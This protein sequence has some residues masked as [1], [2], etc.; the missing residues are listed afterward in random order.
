MALDANIRDVTSGAAV[1]VTTANELTVTGDTVTFYEN[2]DGVATNVRL[3]ESPEVDDDYRLRVALETYLDQET[4]NYTA[5]NT[6]KHKYSNTT[7][8]N[9]PTINGY[10]TNSGSIT[11]LNTATHWQSYAYFPIHGVASTYAEF[12]ASFSSTCPTNTTL[13]FG[14]FVLANPTTPATPYAP[15]DGVYFRY[16]NTGM[17]GVINFNGTETTVGPFVNTFGGSQWTPVAS[18]KYAFNVTI[19]ERN[20]QFWID[21]R[22]YGS[23]VPPIT[24]GQPFVSA[25]LPKAIRH[26]IGSVAASGGFSFLVSDATV[27]MGGPNITDTL[28][29]ISNRTLGSYQGLSGGTMGGTSTY[30]NSTNPTAAAPSNTGL[31]ANL[32]AGLGGQGN[33]TAALAAATDGIWLSFTNPQGATATTGQQPRRLRINGVKLDA[34]NLGAVVATTATTIQFSLAFG[35]TADSL[36]TAEA[37]TTKAPRR[38]GLGFMNWPLGA[39]IGAGPDR[40][41]LTLTLQNP[42]YVNPG[43]RVALVGKFLVGTATASQTIQFTA[44]FDYSFE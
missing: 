7:M 37:A 21:N 14:L 11:T 28:G 2:D 27:S 32:P 13:D 29:A 35:H 24:Q 1:A 34:V 9:A 40:G 23:I 36:V 26:A 31:T 12:S 39:A 43:E 16:I 10:Q 25:A 41:P 33:V 38:L 3:L 42:I 18:Q 4:F 30:V 6:G 15:A 20:V 22:C 44:A 17:Y 5:Q 19:N 8:T